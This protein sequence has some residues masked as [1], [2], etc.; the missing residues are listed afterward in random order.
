FRKLPIAN[1]SFSQIQATAQHAGASLTI[2]GVF[3]AGVQNGTLALVIN[4][5]ATGTTRALVATG[6][7]FLTASDLASVTIASASV[8]FNDAGTDYAATPLILDIH[9]VSATLDAAAGAQSVSLH[10]LSAQ[11]A[12]ALSVSGDFGFRKLTLGPTHTQIEATAQNVSA[13]LGL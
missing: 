5:T 3:Q 8:R 9:G 1:T 10:G 2:P 11:F 6:S 4:Q 13:S 7:A 12:G